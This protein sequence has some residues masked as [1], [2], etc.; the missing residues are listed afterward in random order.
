MKAAILPTST[1]PTR[2]DRTQF[3][4][5]CSE[6]YIPQRSSNILATFWIFKANAHAFKQSNE[7][8]GVLIILSC[9]PSALSFSAIAKRVRSS[10][11]GHWDMASRHPLSRTK[12]NTCYLCTLISLPVRIQML[13][14][15]L[16]LLMAVPGLRSPYHVEISL[17]IYVL[18]NRLSVV[19]YKRVVVDDTNN[20]FDV[21][22]LVRSHPKVGRRE[23]RVIDVMRSAGWWT[24]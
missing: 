3:E 9:I 5:R 8:V 14:T 16:L 7:V 21:E 15:D 10:K 22:Q 4:N 13:I 2:F 11:R 23:Y 1:E 24:E 18:Q 19:K 12:A 17:M 20:I 6:V